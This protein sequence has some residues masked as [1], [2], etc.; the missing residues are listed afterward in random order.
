MNIQ[1]AAGGPSM[2]RKPSVVA[3][4]LISMSYAW[5]PQA[6]AKNAIQPNV[7]A[8][9]WIKTVN[10]L[11][12][13]NNDLAGSYCLA[14]DIDASTKANFVP[15]GTSAAPFTG[16]L[17]G[18]GHVIR[19]LTI[20]SAAT[21][22]GLFGSIDH[23]TLQDV[24]LVNLSISSATG[25]TI[26][27]GLVGAAQGSSASST[28]ARVFVTGQLNYT[29]QD[30]S[31]GGI[32]GSLNN[33][34]LTESWSAVQITGP[35]H[36][37]AG[38][39]VGYLFSSATLSDVSAS[40]TVSCGT[41][42]AAGGLVGIAAGTV[43]SSYA[44]GA[45]HA[46]DD[47][48]VGGAIGFAGR[49]GGTNGAVVQ[50]SYATGP[51]SGG[52]DAS[53][54]GLIGLLSG[55]AVTESYAAGPVTGDIG[56]SV[57]G[58][59]GIISAGPG[60]ASSLTES[61]A[62]GAVSASPGSMRVGGLVGVKGLG[63]ITWDFAYWDIETT[64]Q[65]QS[66]AGTARSTA[67]MRSMVPCC[68]P[69]HSNPWAITSTLSYPYLDDFNI[70]FASPLATLVHSSKVFIFLPL[71]Q[72]DVSQYLTAPMHADGAALAAV[73]TMVARAVGLT[74]NDARL[75]DVKIDRFFWDDATQT[76]TWKGPVRTHATL[77]AMTTISGSTPL[78]GTNVVGRMKAEKLVILRGTYRKSDGSIGTHWLLGTLYT[79][80]ADGSVSTVV[81]NDPLTGEQI[82]IDP[83]TKKVLSPNFPLAKF[84]VNGYQ[85]VTLN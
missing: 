64:G 10:Q 61:Y 37:R 53:V 48:E 33:T 69:G 54:G 5:N 23:A 79:K 9:T 25:E 26:I 34:T 49:E 36:T 52:P 62:V 3:V 50:R 18:D 16:R 30:S 73:Y 67:D 59:I 19:N 65:F 7:V 40:G 68:L 43:L 35:D 55:A 46:S 51:V 6:V 63:T 83:L 42:C 14:N 56:A 80:H 45:V 74:D 8:C 15:V 75:K 21:N 58:L 11:Q 66:A 70:G 77:G 76:A 4:T 38:G 17:Y 13:M 71:G 60:E 39:A 44:S 84:K 22:V 20:T 82:E 28:V 29:G 27:G 32:V 41:N 24:G 78:N 12:A 1:Q 47:S 57:G 2:G 31:V 72:L 85:A 81:A